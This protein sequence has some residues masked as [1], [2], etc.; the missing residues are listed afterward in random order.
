MVFDSVL[1]SK[2]DQRLAVKQSKKDER[3]APKDFF[4]YREKSREELRKERDRK[5]LE[6]NSSESDFEKRVRGVIVGVD[7]L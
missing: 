4:V 5:Y 3:F 6:D 7:D 2:L 1:R